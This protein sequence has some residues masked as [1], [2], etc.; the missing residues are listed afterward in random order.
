MH[1]GVYVYETDIPYLPTLCGDNL[2]EAL[3]KVIIRGIS[4]TNFKK[5]TLCSSKYGIYLPIT[6]HDVYVISTI[7]III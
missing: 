3:L 4:Q 2:R 7:T 5:S 1:A 6:L